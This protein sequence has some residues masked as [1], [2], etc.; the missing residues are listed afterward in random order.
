MIEMSVE[1]VATDPNDQQRIVWLRTM[2]GNRLIPI[3]IG[4][5]EAFSIALGLSGQEAP[6]PLAH[7]LIRSILDRLQASIDRIEIVSMKDGTFYAQLILA[8]PDGHV[9]IDARPSDCLA[10]AL[11]AGAPIYVT[12]DLLTAE[13]ITDERTLATIA[14]KP[15]IG[16]EKAKETPI[17]LD[18]LDAEIR[19]LIRSTGLDEEDEKAG[20]YSE[21]PLK[22]L[23]WRLELA[24]KGEDYER[25]AR[26][27]DEIARRGKHGESVAET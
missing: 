25:A 9:S 16:A 10:L 13:G 11:R 19:S 1:R 7:D 21:I 8:G 2:Q 27:R 26:L 5:G 17:S 4:E 24:I 23:R 20:H 12:E 15:G 3:A 22:K 14:R 6:R 18:N